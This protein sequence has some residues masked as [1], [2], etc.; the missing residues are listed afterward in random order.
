MTRRLLLEGPGKWRRGNGDVVP[1]FSMI[2]P[3]LVAALR[4]VDAKHAEAIAT[5]EQAKAVHA[6]ASSKLKMTDAEAE[7]A[8]AQ[9]REMIDL[10]ER[11][12][13]E[14]RAQIAFHDRDRVR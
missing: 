6:S 4:I 3:H 11:K 7:E 5:L 8:F 9:I 10:L 12:A 13:T 2:Y 1:I 14:L